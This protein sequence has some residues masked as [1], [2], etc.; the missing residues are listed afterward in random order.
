VTSKTSIPADREVGTTDSR[1]YCTECGTTERALMAASPSRS[2]QEARGKPVYC[3]ECNPRFRFLDA[4]WSCLER[5][6]S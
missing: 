2:A 6:G 4:H 1:R 3:M 5:M